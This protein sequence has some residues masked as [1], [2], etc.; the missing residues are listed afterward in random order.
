MFA[1]AP[2]I[3]EYVHVMKGRKNKDI[4]KEHFDGSLEKS[5][6]I[7]DLINDGIALKDPTPVE[8]RKQLRTI[9]RKA[10]EV[11]KH[12]EKYNNLMYKPKRTR[13]SHNT[14]LEKLRPI[15]MEMALFADWEYGV[16][17]K[18]RQDVTKDLCDYIRN[19]NLRNEDNKAVILPDAKL[20]KLLQIDDDVILRYPTMQKY[21]FNCF[22]EETEPPPEEEDDEPI[23]KEIAKK[24]VKKETAKKEPIKKEPVK[25]EPVKKE[26]VKKEPVKKEPVKKGKK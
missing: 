2:K 21:L 13:T 17:R 4:A 14:G 10:K 1:Q 25:K 8:M 26:P 6:L 19:N 9:L 12:L 20:K 24:A 18:S 3:V 23:K 11:K 5:I 15:S 16:T 22:E 7:L